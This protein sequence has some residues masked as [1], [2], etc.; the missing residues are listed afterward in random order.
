MPSNKAQTSVIVIGPPPGDGA[1][2]TITA[3][4]T[5]LLPGF[6]LQGKASRHRIIGE[7]VEKID[8]APLYAVQHREWF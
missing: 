2:I 4:M 7:Q 5:A 3:K 8:L 1:S 6:A